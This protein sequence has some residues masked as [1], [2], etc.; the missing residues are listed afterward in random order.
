MKIRKLEALY[1]IRTSKG[2]IA[3]G[4]YSVDSLGGIP[5]VL[6]EEAKRGASTVR[7]LSYDKEV[8]E[9][10]EA[11]PEG[12]EA[13]EMTMLDGGEGSVNLNEEPEEIEPEPEPE[14]EEE[15]IEPEP[16]VKPKIKPRAKPK[17]EPKE[18]PVR[19]VTRKKKE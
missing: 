7:V 15:E 14:A 5:K 1:T 11:Q 18:K 10:V 16:E 2:K 4:V 9:V 8:E 17:A 13:G 12:R 6:L 19:R 3:K